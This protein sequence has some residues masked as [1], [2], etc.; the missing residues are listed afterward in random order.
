MIYKV[1]FQPSALREL[2][3]LPRDVQVRVVARAEALAKNPRPEGVKKLAGLEELY[4]LRV[5]DY[6]VIYQIQD[7]RLVVL[8]VRIRH[9]RDVYRK[10]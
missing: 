3:K 5:G 8:V 6:R 7:Q 4:R 2:R 9:R 1:F 10:G